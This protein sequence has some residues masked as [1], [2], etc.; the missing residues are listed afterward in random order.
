MFF[1]YDRRAVDRM[2]EL[3]GYQ[4]ERRI[5]RGGMAEVWLGVQRRT[6]RRVAIKCVLPELARQRDFRELFASEGRINARLNHPSIVHIIEVINQGQELA[7]VLE[8]LDGGDLHQ[9]LALGMHMSSA[10]AVIRALCHALD[11]AHSQGVI[12][13]DV[14]PENILFREDDT[15]VLTD[16]GLARLVVRGNSQSAHGTVFGSPQYMS[17]EQIAG[18]PLDGRS[19]LYSLGVVFYQI[20]TGDVPFKGEDT[21]VIATKHLQEPVPRLPLHLAV[22]Q[23]VIDTML[24]KKP[25]LRFQTG[26]QMADALESVR[27][28]GAVPNATIRTEAVTSQEIRA[29][30]ASILVT[31]KD[32]RR[33]AERGRRRQR[34]RLVSLSLATAT[35]IVVL[36]MAG[37]WIATHPERL[38]LLLAD[39]GIT[40][41]PG[42]AEAWNE[43]RSLRQDPSQGLRTL[44]AAYERV[45]A[46]DPLHEGARA[47]IGSLADE[48]KLTIR[49]AL[50]ESNFGTAEARLAEARLAF[51]DDPDFKDFLVELDD[52][53]NAE[54][55]LASTQ[56]LL[57]SHGLSDTPSAT[58]A[59]Q[60]F[61]E[62]LRLA[63]GHPE[64][65][66]E[67][68]AIADHYALLAAARVEAGDMQAAIGDLD[69]ASTANPA[70]PAI[71]TIRQS[72]QQANS[73]LATIAE[74]LEQARAHRESGALVMPSG[75]NA[76]ALYHQVLSIDPA[77]AIAKQ[78]LNEVVAQLRAR[79]AAEIR[80]GEFA[81]VAEIISQASSVNLDPAAIEEFR[82]QLITEQT[83]IG[84]LN[85]LLEE[86][87]RYIADGYLTE[88]DGANA[89][90]SLREVQRLDPANKEADLLLKQVAERLAQVAKEANMANLHREAQQYLDL[91]LAIVPGVTEWQELRE[92]W[93]RAMING[94]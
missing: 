9:R 47:D 94:R 65:R 11:Y 86:A 38:Q 63:P 81:S 67:L 89:T 22:F 49:T 20:L 83:R 54:G 75:D 28:D 14:K 56:A 79:V 51:P 19:D 33:Q 92:E 25:E 85:R 61:N 71:A 8:Y 44:V 53:R 21:T 5:G 27:S 24:A 15:P 74:F 82:K 46:I 35:G 73:T 17:P 7:L 29:V 57:R 52:R 32:P 6:G 50:A 34:R 78:G 84:N 62:V 26:A 69:R 41:R 16:F 2:L 59:I 70:L 4:I 72:I 58:A 88:P 45:L 80:R 43:A 76:A 23:R 13:R 1:R 37:Y 10:I 64:A 68:D 36:S 91:A 40:E 18:L 3:P 77:N 12:H 87:R 60:A 31:M 66:A 90:L 55:L 42:L 39:V 93:S 30:T 48:W